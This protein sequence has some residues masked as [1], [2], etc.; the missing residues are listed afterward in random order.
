MESVIKEIDDVA[1]E[2]QPA[3]R[4][5][6]QDDALRHAVDH[7]RTLAEDSRRYHRHWQASVREAGLLRAE[8]EAVKAELR[9]ELEAVKGEMEAVEAE[10]AAIRA[11]R[12]FRFLQRLYKIRLFL[13]PH[14]SRRERWGAA[15]FRMVRGRG[16]GPAEVTLPV[17]AAAPMPPVEP[18][19]AAVE[20]LPAAVEAPQAVAELPRGGQFAAKG[21]AAAGADGYR[22]PGV[23]APPLATD[24]RIAA[25][26]SRPQSDHFV[27]QSPGRF[28]AFA[29]DLQRPK[30]DA[31]LGRTRRSAQTF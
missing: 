17:S 20:P 4:A 1:I 14:G 11:S 18:P 16:H 13:M 12:G 25:G 5:A 28:H 26:G 9:A 21:R 22:R 6:N 3:G 29:A 30:R 7:M 19:Q 8:M 31:D 10:L 2:G 23:S 27:G 24:R 15:V